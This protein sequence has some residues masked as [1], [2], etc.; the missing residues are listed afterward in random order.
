MPPL[1]QGALVGGAIACG[2]SSYIGQKKYLN[3]GKKPSW[4]GVFVGAAGGAL[5]GAFIGASV[6]SSAS[7]VNDVNR[8]T[9][10]SIDYI[11]KG[12]A[13]VWSAPKYGFGESSGYVGFGPGVK[14]FSWW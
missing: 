5:T 3:L 4:V 1:S 12:G 8:A 7:L 2:A 11:P 13:D 10:T 14:P 6:G 9:T